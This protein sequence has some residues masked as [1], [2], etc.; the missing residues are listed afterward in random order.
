MPREAPP[1]L[2]SAGKRAARAA[3]GNEGSL[4]ASRSIEGF[5]GAGGPTVRGG[6]LERERLGARVGR[7]LADELAAPLEVVHAVVLEAPLLGGA[8]RVAVS[9]PLLLAE[10]AE[11]HACDGQ[12]D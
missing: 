11:A 12:V 2:P 1:L 10:H 9:P 6:A 3:A 5:R 7:E 8:G 4:R